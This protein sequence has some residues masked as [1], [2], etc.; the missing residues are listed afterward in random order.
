MIMFNGSLLILC[1]IIGLYKTYFSKQKDKLICTDQ[2]KF[3]SFLVILAGL[4]LIMA[5]TLK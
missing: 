5:S 1:G 2:L 3:V 4:I